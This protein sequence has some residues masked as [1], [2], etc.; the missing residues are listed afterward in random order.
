VNV[1]VIVAGSGA[2]LCFAFAFGELRGA[3]HGVPILIAREL[4]L[5]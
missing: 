4:N 2:A 5:Q 3:F 1:S